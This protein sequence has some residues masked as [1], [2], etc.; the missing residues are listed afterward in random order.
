MR[1][2]QLHTTIAPI[3]LAG[4]LAIAAAPGTFAADGT[5]PTQ[6]EVTQTLGTLPTTLVLGGHAWYLNED[7]NTYVRDAKRITAKPTEEEKKISAKVLDANPEEVLKQAERAQAHYESE[8]RNH[9]AAEVGNPSITVI[10]PGPAPSTAE[11]APEEDNADEQAQL[12][13]QG[14]NPDTASEQP[15]EDA[16]DTADTKPADNGDSAEKSDKADEGANAANDKAAEEA[17]AKPADKAPETP[18]AA[19][20]DRGVGAQTGYNETAQSL[21]GIL[22]AI[23]AG[24]AVYSTRRLMSKAA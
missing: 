19:V 17:D 15:A 1:R 21:A 3:A 20:T 4:A 7:G 18:E 22:L 23:A 2:T 14:E 12:L 13:A 16:A 8:A 24:S 10:K 6:A 5:S 11:R 9:Y